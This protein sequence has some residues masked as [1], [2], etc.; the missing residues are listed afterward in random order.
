MAQNKQTN[1]RRT[2]HYFP[3]QSSTIQFLVCFILIPVQSEEVHTYE[4]VFISGQHGNPTCKF[5]FI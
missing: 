5:T 4:Y 3:S 1:F 2:A